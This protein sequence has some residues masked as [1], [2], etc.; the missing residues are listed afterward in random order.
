[1]PSWDRFLEVAGLLAALSL[2][3]AESFLDQ[4][5]ALA[6]RKKHD[7]S[8]KLHTSLKPLGTEES[9]GS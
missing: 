5:W 3:V 9:T 2:I 7:G 6:L 8:D 1:M 4:V